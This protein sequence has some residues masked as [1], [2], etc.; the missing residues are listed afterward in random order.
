MQVSWLVL[1]PPVLVIALAFITHR[2]LLALAIGI[3]IGAAIVANFSLYQTIAI[4]AHNIQAQ[5]ELANM[6]TF[7]F[8]LLLG[9]LITL[10]GHTGGTIAYGKLIK[11]RL[12][13]AKTSETASVL[14]SF[15]FAIDDFFS[16][17]T[18]GSI[19]KP[20]TDSFK[21]P[22]IKLAFLIDSLAAPL[23]ILVPV[24][25]W[26]AM[27]LMQLEKG[28]VS[29]NSADQPLILEDPFAFYLQTIPFIFYSFIISASV[30]YIVRSRSS[31]GLMNTHE[32]IAHETGNL[33]G[34]ESVPTETFKSSN[35]ATGTLLD[36]IFPLASLISFVV[37]AVLYLGDSKLFG[38]SN[39]L[40][41]TMQQTDI[42]LALLIG[43]CASFILSVLLALA[44]KTLTVSGL[45]VLAHGGYQL[46]KDSIALLFLA[47]TFGTLLKND[48]HTGDYLAQILI[49][50]VSSAFL[51]AMF[52]ITSLITAVGTGSSWGTIAVLVPL[53][54]PLVTSFTNVT[55]P[56]SIDH[57]VLLL[58]VIGAVFAGA[59][60]GDH[61]SPIGTTTI[62]TAAST[63]ANLHAHI[64]SQLPYALP[65]LFATFIAYLIAGIMMPY[66]A[67]ISCTVSLVSG[68]TIAIMI[69]MLINYLTKKRQI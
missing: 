33:F 28:G 32:E 29:I 57:I 55:T 67:L 46:M 10:M 68:I 54:I 59:V 26:I 65:A 56:T 27:V 5:F 42:F 12:T 34:G 52:Y 23:I 48:L 8:L 7:G 3:V 53:A 11:K 4:I 35:T 9:A 60:A 40:N 38:G 37:I 16:I 63:E 61:V 22:R 13:S 39:S 15:C 20:V 2:V 31:W 21:I 69:L 64:Y 51:P 58:P 30:I 1:I 14:L 50:S 36:F 43:C 47:W 18:V 17:L 62:M 41:Q 25:T 49:G 19:M 44:R 24:S 6:Y 66:G 45:P